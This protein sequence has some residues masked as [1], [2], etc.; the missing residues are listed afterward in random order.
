LHVADQVAV[1]RSCDARFA[2]AR[3][4]EHRLRARQQGTWLLPGHH[5]RSRSHAPSPAV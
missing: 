2:K 4:A 1:R 5:E 3:L